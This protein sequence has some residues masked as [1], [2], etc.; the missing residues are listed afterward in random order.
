[1][2]LGQVSL[3]HPVAL[4]LATMSLTWVSFLTAKRF[5]RESYHSA[6]NG[7]D[8]TAH[9][10]VERVKSEGTLL[11]PAPPTVS[12]GNYLD[13]RS[14]PKRPLSPRLCKEHIRLHSLDMS[15]M[16]HVAL[17]VVDCQPVYWDKQEVVRK[18]FP[19]LP[20]EISKLL[21]QARAMLSPPQIVHVRANYT[22]RFAQNFKLLNPDKP[23]PSDIQAIDWASSK[24]GEQI[25]VKSSFDSFHETSLK[26]YLR[27]LGVTD[28]IICGLLT[29]CCV[30]FTA[31]SAF[32]SGFRVR[33]Y[34]PGC[35]D[36][37]T[38]RHLQTIETY[39]SYCF[40]VFRDLDACFTWHGLPSV[41]PLAISA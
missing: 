4:A 14:P 21:R 30:L 28:I 38:S 18:A 31:Q 1:M 35:G 15:V 26:H 20:M 12:L 24:V 33:L 8:I 10:V 22:F 40:E 34:E 9:T 19:R 41:R 13:H 25:V 3:Q 7:E 17:V 5:S 2:Q 32:A 36:R 29:S 6:H 37:S 23:L 16:Q 39:G 27:E 11:E